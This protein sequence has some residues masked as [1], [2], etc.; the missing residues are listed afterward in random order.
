MKILKAV[1]T[2]ILLGITSFALIA[3]PAFAQMKFSD[4]LVRHYN[5]KEVAAQVVSIYKP[6]AKEA[7]NNA[8]EALNAFRDQINVKHIPGVFH[9]QSLSDTGKY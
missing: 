8:E 5:S 7:L 4:K 6:I 3:T 2:V 9:L 1:T